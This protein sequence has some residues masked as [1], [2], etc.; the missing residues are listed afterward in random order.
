MFGWA[1]FTEDESTDAIPDK[2]ILTIT[3]EDGE[4]FATIVRRTVDGEYPLDGGLA[5][6]KRANAQRIVNAL[7]REED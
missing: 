3:D 4:E 5:S 2:F 1:D 6:Q 7:N